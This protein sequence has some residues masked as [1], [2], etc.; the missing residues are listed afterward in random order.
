MNAY[1]IFSVVVLVVGV[2]GIT[3]LSAMFNSCEK[4][5][6]IDAE[7]NVMRRVDVNTLSNLSQ[8]S[9]VNHGKAHEVVNE[10]HRKYLTDLIAHMSLGNNNFEQKIKILEE[11]LC[12]TTRTYIQKTNEN[13]KV[14][15][16]KN[17]NID[18]IKITVI[19]VDAYI[20]GEL[21]KKVLDRYAKKRYGTIFWNFIRPIAQNSYISK[22]E[23]KEI[24]NCIHAKI[25]KLKVEYMLPEYPNGKSLGNL[26]RKKNKKNI[27]SLCGKILRA[28]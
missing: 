27:R 12:V 16:N 22:K 24:Y 23:K 18:I 28:R 10:E 8:T 15:Q 20:M 3:R 5:I 2:S 19:A 6:F 14:L 7:K 1:R 25:K 13:Y 4:N 26:L 21:K 17:P 9:A 11:G